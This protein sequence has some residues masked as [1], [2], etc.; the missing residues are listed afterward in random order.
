MQART[1]TSNRQAK[2]IK[3]SHG[4]RVSPHSQAK[5]RV[6]RTMDN[7]RE[8]QKEPKVGSKFPKAQATVKHRIRVSQVLKT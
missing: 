8:S 1:L 2:A 4:P 6:K 7:P 3:A 5:G